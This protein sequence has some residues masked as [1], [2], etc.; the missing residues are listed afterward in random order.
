MALCRQNLDRPL[1]ALRDERKSY[2]TRLGKAVRTIKDHVNDSLYPLL[3]GKTVLEMWSI[4]EGRFQHISP[5]SIASTLTD[6]C[7]KKLPGFKNVIE[8]ISS[9]QTTYDKVP[10]LVKEGPRMHMETAEIFSQ[11]NIIRNLGPAYKVLESVIHDVWKE[12][13]I[14]LPDIISIRRYPEE[15]IQ[16]TKT[17]D[18]TAFAT[19]IH[20]ASKGACTTKDCVERGL[21]T[22]YNDR[23]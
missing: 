5:V 6:G 16:H 13:T 17:S 2:R 20:R 21:N 9:Y 23:C 8:Y 10:N 14:N 4:L 22:H 7:M 19:S 11:V 3:L 12:E 15:T 18:A 1:L